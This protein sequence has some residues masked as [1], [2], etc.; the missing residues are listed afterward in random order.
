MEGNSLA[1]G[2]LK[3]FKSVQLNGRLFANARLAKRIQKAKNNIYEFFFE[4]QH[5]T[6]LLNSSI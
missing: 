1:E 3:G 4:N 5:E 2:E 6:L